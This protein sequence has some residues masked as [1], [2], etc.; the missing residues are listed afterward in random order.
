[1]FSK[2]LHLAA[3][4]FLV[5]LSVSREAANAPFFHGR[6]QQQSR[7]EYPLLTAVF[8]ALGGVIRVAL[9]GAHG[10]PLRAGEAETVLVD[11]SQSTEQRAERAVDAISAPLRTDI[12]GSA[13]YRRALLIQTFRRALET[14]G[15]NP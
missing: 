13:D 11:R 1:V 10:F 14:L 8:V 12:R 9:S 15:G 3:G 4:E 7:V 5:S 2:R 6:R